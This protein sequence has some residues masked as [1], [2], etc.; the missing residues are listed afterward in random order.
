MS[1]YSPPPR[2]LIS[3]PL[4]L[5][6]SPLHQKPQPSGGCVRGVPASLPTW[7]IRACCYWAVSANS[8]ATMVWLSPRFSTRTRHLA[9]TGYLEQPNSRSQGVE[10]RWVLL[11]HSV[12]RSICTRSASP[13]TITHPPVD[14][15]IVDAAINLPPAWGNNNGQTQYDK[16]PLNMKGW[17]AHRHETEGSNLTRK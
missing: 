5:Q 3:S 17:R 4:P 9:S 16:K 7:K 15:A 13:P 6:V 2:W 12:A 8:L 10:T 1:V 14:K 11:C